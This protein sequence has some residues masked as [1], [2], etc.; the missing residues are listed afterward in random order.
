MLPLHGRR[1]NWAGAVPQLLPS[2]CRQ[3]A[4]VAPGTAEKEGQGDGASC[5]G[6]MGDGDSPPRRGGENLASFPLPPAVFT[7]RVRSVCLIFPPCGA[8][9]PAV[10]HHPQRP[11]PRFLWALRA[12]RRIPQPWASTTRCPRSRARRD[13][14]GGTQRRCKGCHEQKPGS[15]RPGAAPWRARRARPCVGAGRRAAGRGRV[16]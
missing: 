1:G 13:R 10:R 8:L 9:A 3:W 15:G 2:G 11:R 5:P 14:A 12:L 16:M 4:H 6:E 7:Y